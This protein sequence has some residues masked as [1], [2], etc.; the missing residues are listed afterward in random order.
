GRRRTAPQPRGAPRHARRAGGSPRGGLAHRSH[1]RRAGAARHARAARRPPRAR[2][3]ARRGERVIRTNLSTRPFYDERTLNVWLLA[4][5][6]G[7]AA[8]T[9]YNVSRIVRYS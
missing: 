4:V 2:P 7:V 8:A 9:V 3:D 1:H 6:L 5:A